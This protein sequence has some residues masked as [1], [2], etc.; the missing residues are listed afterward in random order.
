MTCDELQ[1]LVH[2]YMDN[3]LDPARC[4]DLERHLEGCDACRRSVQDW[5]KLRA[6][7]AASKLYFRASDTL[8]QRI[9]SR[10][11]QISRAMNSRRPWRSAIATAAMLL[12]IIGVMWAGI[13]YF[14]YAG[15]GD[16]L[17][18]E[19]VADHVRSLMVDH[20]TDVQS[21]DQHTVKPWFDGKID[22]SPMV[23]DFAEQ[24]FPLVGGRLDYLADRPVAALVYHR[25]QHYI[26]VFLWPAGNAAAEPQ[27]SMNRDGYNVIHW[28]QQGMNYWMVSNL[29]EEEL[30]ILAGLLRQE[31]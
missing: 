23:R 9:R 29:N 14:R 3:E 7:L 31:L 20:L 28:S 22:F 4:L 30:L 10:L 12:L 25:R 24:G 18:R 2:A 19:V 5:Q 13:P 11:K 16:A 15:D 26:N 8:R 1:P 17:A 27:K 21:S 6:Q